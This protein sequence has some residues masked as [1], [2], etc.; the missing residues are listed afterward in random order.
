MMCSRLVRTTRPV[1]TISM[2]QMVSRTTANASCPTFRSAPNS[3]AGSVPRVDA[4]LRDELVNVNRASGF[5]G[6]VFQFVLRHFNVG[7]G[8]DLLTLYNFVRRNFLTS[9]SIHFQVFDA[10]VFL[11]IWLKLIFP[12][13]EVAGY[14]AIG[15]VTREKRAVKEA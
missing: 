6:D 5:E 7:V 9:V 3:R 12:E 10:P 1:A 15:Q 14:K 4:A 8:I 11:L 2:L 13:S